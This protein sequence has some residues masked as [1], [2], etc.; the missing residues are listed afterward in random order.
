M[1]AINFPASPT[2]GA[3]HT[4]AGITWTFDGATWDTTGVGYVQTSSLPVYAD[5]AAAKAGGLTSGKPYRTATGQL[6]VVF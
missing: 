2:T 5:N 4:D 3:T 6:M 1:T